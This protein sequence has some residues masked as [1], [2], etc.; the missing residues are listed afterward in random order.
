[1]DALVIGDTQYKISLLVT[2]VSTSLCLAVADAPENSSFATPQQA[3]L[4]IAGGT[5]KEEL[6]GHRFIGKRDDLP[7]R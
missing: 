5:A 4:A 2:A 1:M 6:I 7:R 3:D